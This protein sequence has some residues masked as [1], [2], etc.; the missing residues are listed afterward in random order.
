MTNLVSRPNSPRGRRRREELIEAGLA[1]LVE[2]GWP[3]VT[4]RAVAA[5]GDAN[6]GLIHYHFGGLPALHLAIARQA[7]EDVMM[8]LV[9]DLLSSPDARTALDVLRNAVPRIT[10]DE[11]TLR[12]AVELTAG[13]LRNPEIGEAL[14]QGLREARARIADWLGTLDPQVP[15]ERR[16]GAATLVAALID[17]MMLHQLLDEE[18]PVQAALTALGDLIGAPS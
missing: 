5:R 8:P 16:A 10:E 18:V 1:L 13:A 4:T 11:K 3:A 14:R 9:E 7:G 17:G 6:V 15:A 12:L 2:G